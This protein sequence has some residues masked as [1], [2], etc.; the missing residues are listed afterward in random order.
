MPGVG[1]CFCAA[2]LAWREEHRARTNAELSIAEEKVKFN[3]YINR[4]ANQVIGDRRVVYLL[5]SVENVGKRAAA[6]H[7]WRA[8]VQ[9]N[10]GLPE[11]VAVSQPAVDDAKHETRV[12]QKTKTRA[13]GV[14]LEPAVGLEPTAC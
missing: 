8:F 11:P 13:W 12:R 7:H 4:M 3:S 10:D 9:R 5:V 6:L 14:V 1:L 2:Y